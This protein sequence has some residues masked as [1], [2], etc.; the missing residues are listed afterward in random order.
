VN[1]KR[2]TTNRNS[3]GPHP[4]SWVPVLGPAGTLHFVTFSAGFCRLLKVSAGMVILFVF[5][6][7]VAENAP[8]AQGRPCNVSYD[9]RYTKYFA[10]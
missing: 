6:E 10:D 7:W 8:I 4:A 2:Q 9:K 1:A 3:S 5:R